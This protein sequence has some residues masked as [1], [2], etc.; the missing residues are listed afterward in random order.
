MSDNGFG[1]LLFIFI[2]HQQRPFPLT[3]AAKTDKAS[4]WVR[5]VVVAVV[6]MGKERWPEQQSTQQTRAVEQCMRL[7]F[8]LLDVTEMF[9]ATFTPIQAP[10]QPAP[11]AS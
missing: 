7:K 11:K 2:H 3:Q 6:T 5:S 4:S 1:F 8:S 10:K 9:P